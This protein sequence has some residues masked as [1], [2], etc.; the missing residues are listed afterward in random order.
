LFDDNDR[1]N[2]GNK[3]K[4]G[5]SAGENFFSKITENDEDFEEPATISAVN[6]EK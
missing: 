2:Y 4:R 6:E 1:E 5:Y 3:R